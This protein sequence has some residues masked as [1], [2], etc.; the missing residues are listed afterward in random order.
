MT[1]ELRWIQVFVSWNKLLG[2]FYINMSNH[3]NYL[4]LIVDQNR[5]ACKA[6]VWENE[7]LNQSELETET[8][9]INQHNVKAPEATLVSHSYY[10]LLS[11]LW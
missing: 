5:L 8:N 10:Q 1:L 2:S 9:S 3:V 11:I 6:I 7:V 4:K